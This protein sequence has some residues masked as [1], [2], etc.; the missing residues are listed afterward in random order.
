MGT[1]PYSTDGAAPMA[2]APDELTAALAIPTKPPAMVDAGPGPNGSHWIL[3]REPPAAAARAAA[4]TSKVGRGVLKPSE[5]DNRSTPAPS[6]YSIVAIGGRPGGGL[7]DPRDS[8]GHIP[9]LLQGNLGMRG[10][11]SLRGCGIRQSTP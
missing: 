9:K 1:Q 11:A 6:A 10:M 8:N 4:D 2:A 7:A 5:Q 3:M